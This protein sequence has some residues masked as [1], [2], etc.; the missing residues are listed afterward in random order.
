M[1]GVDQ[2]SQHGVGW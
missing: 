1:D 2:Q